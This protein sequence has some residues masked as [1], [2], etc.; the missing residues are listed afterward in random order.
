VAKLGRWRRVVIPKSFCERMGLREGDPIEFSSSNKRIVIKL[1]KKRIPNPGPQKY[2]RL[3]PAEEKTVARSRE[4]FK[5]GEY[6]TLDQLK[7]ELGL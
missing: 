3:S 4:Q 7:D 6:V 2:A 1:G 5:R